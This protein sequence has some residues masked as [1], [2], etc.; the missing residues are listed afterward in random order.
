MP[1]GPLEIFGIFLLI[2]IIAIILSRSFRIV[3][4]WERM[5]VLRLGKYVGIKG[6]GLAFL[7]PFI[8]RGI[9]VDTRINT[10]DV[11]KQD[12][13]TRD[14]VTVRVDAVVYYRVLD[15]EKAVMKVRD[16]NYAIALLGQTTL[17]DVVGQ[18]E[19]DDILS[20]REEINKRIQSII[21]EITE[22]WGIKVSMVTLKAV[23]LPEGMIRAMAYQAE[24]ERIRRARIIEAEAER[25]A[26]KILLEAAQTYEQHPVALRLREL[27][28]YVDIAKEKNIIIITESGVSRTVSEAIASSLALEKA[29]QYEK[30]SKE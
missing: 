7:I 19:L 8:D 22:P 18:L 1:I 26:A 16:Y 2:I 25:A 20:K 28:T 14:N 21:D 11:P 3:R 13:I 15:P 12:V 27:Q 17:R 30:A 23:E 6:P 4:E 24:A 29:K 9:V 5:V 10:V